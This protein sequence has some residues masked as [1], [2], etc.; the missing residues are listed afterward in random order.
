M[1][2]AKLEDY[3]KLIQRKVAGKVTDYH[4][5][6][7][8]CQECRI[9]VWQSFGKYTAEE[10]NGMTLKSWVSLQV[11]SVISNFLRD[12]Y[13]T[14]RAQREIPYGLLLDA[15]LLF[16]ERRFEEAKEP[17]EKRGAGDQILGGEPVSDLFRRWTDSREREETELKELEEEI[18]RNLKPMQVEIYKLLKQGY[19]QREIAVGL[20]HGTVSQPYVHKQIDSIKEVVRRVLGRR[21]FF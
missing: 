16:G 7:D 20:D 14:E 5:F 15:E 12:T 4:D 18:L 17:E 21:R 8:C 6:Q 9:R 3:E 10:S 13:Y 19:T 1:V 11:D 2:A